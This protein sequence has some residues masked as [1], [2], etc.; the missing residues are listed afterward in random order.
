MKILK[1]AA[2]LAGCLMLPAIAS[3]AMTETEFKAEAKQKAMQL[4]QT[5][6]QNLQ[7]AVK[8]GGL[9]NGVQVCKDI[10]P[11][12]AAELS[13]DG[14]QVGRTALK[15]RNPA[16]RADNWEHSALLTMVKKLEEGL[17]PGALVT[18]SVEESTGIYRFMAPIM[19]DGLCLNCHGADLAPDVKATILQQ[20]PQDE[21][22]GFAAGDL[23]GAFT[24]SYQAQAG[25]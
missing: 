20:Y 4:G 9:A 15:V 5:L 21:A 18:V 16:N 7:K 22:T 11:V 19:T 24:V 14:W 17:E 3:A 8:E 23:R 25:E 6:R 1:S 2:V 12:I 10:A 13:T